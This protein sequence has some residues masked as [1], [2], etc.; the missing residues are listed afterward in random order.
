MYFNL[1]GISG[2]KK[3]RKSRKRQKKDIDRIQ[4]TMIVGNNIMRSV[5]RVIKWKIKGKNYTFN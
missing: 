1:F 4:K 5:S 3:D 2:K